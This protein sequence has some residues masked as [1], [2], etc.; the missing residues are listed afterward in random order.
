MTRADPP[1]NASEASA[2]RRDAVAEM[3]RLGDAKAAADFLRAHVVVSN[4]PGKQTQA[5]LY[6]VVDI[7]GLP[8]PVSARQTAAGAR[9][10]AKREPNRV[11]ALHWIRHLRDAGVY[12]ALSAVTARTSDP[13]AMEEYATVATR[14]HAAVLAEKV[15]DRW[16]RATGQSKRLRMKCN[17]MFF[18]GWVAGSARFNTLGLL[19]M[20][21]WG[22][23]RFEASMRGRPPTATTSVEDAARAG[24]SSGKSRYGVGAAHR[25]PEPN[26]SK[27]CGA[28]G[29]ILQE[30]YA[31]AQ[32]S[33]READALDAFVDDVEAGG[34]GGWINQ[35]DFR[36]IRGQRRCA[37]PHCPAA[38]H[39]LWD[40]D[41]GAGASIRGAALSLARGEGQPAFMT[42]GHD[43]GPVPN[44]YYHAE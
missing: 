41:G 5:F 22:A 35:S 19:P 34:T 31:R 2:R 8:T 11:R 12:R 25:I 4:D 17:G 6:S 23:A 36:H 9:D 37:N 24:L 13:V 26:S 21:A 29:F 1:K 28:C 15:K 20:F 44:A 33:S 10:F 14:H 30:I 39:R 32:T 40:R 7:D 38:A 18:G 42:R 43:S 16:P 3:K 27:D